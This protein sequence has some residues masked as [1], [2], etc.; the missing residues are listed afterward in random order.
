TCLR[1]CKKGLKSTRFLRFRAILQQ[2]RKKKCETRKKV[3]PVLLRAQK[4][5]R[6]PMHFGYAVQHAAMS[7]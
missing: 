3:G 7:G 6:G 2:T 5:F 4:I 1:T